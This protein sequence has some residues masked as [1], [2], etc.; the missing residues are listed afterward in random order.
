MTST[1]GPSRRI[2]VFVV[3]Y[4]GALL[5]T[6]AVLM[7]EGS[8]AGLLSAGYLLAGVICSV[9]AAT[10]G[11]YAYGCACARLQLSDCRISTS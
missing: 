11:K 5:V 4:S 8:R 3:A 7:S 2:P 9:I 6:L 10:F 1:S